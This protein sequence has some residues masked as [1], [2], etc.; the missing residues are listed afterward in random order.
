MEE[1]RA[2][3]RR[4][5]VA[6]LAAALLPLAA[7]GCVVLVSERPLLMLGTAAGREQRGAVAIRD[8]VT[9]FQKWG[10]RAFTVPYLARHY[11]CSGYFT[12]EGG[13][14]QKEQF[15]D[16]L[17]RCL[18]ECEAVDLF[19]LA[20]SNSYIA[21]VEELDPSLTRRL[22]LV[23]NTGC[24]D[25]SQAPRWLGVGADAYIGHPGR[26]ESPVF[27]VYFLR[28]WTAGWSVEAA[29]SEANRLARRNFQSA[30][31]LTGGKVRADVLWRRSGALCFGRTDITIRDPGQ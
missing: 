16:C 13:D 8:N 4:R 1:Q 14:D 11:G 28:R 24:G 6:V 2:S 20:H 21:W 15:L 23:Y 25:A 10:T 7:V 26:S 30:Q 31:W 3:R 17:G 18:T 22:R 5:T 12:Q 19:L 9:A 29:A 27:Y